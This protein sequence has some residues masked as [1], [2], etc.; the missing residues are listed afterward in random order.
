MK[1]TWIVAAA[2]C[3][4]VILSAC[5]K[6]AKN[7]ESTANT[8]TESTVSESGNQE[9][10]ASVSEEAPGKTEEFKIL[11]GKVTKVADTL[12]SMTMVNDGTETTF[13]L[14]NVV[15]E[16]SYALEPDVEV[17]VIYKGEISG[18]DTSNAKII[19]VL[20]SQKSMKVQEAAGSVTDQAM[21]S[22]T[23]KTE[24]G[25][26]LGF[27]KDNCEGLESGVLGKAADD[28]NGSGAMVKV[29]YVTVSYDA[30]SKSNFPL[31]VEAVK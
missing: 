24:D 21:S 10:S 30:D 3:A 25:T 31:K 23:I 17:S 20:D 13:D 2:V 6:S 16:T 12:D 1:R 26:E 22:F 8:V 11:T 15:V 29:T 14:S 27:L 9:S 18:R 19:L 5:G 7:T 4:A 28:S